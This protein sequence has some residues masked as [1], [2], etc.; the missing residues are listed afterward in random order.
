MTNARPPAVADMFYP[1][2][3]GI[4]A[5]TVDQLLADAPATPASRPKA[6]IVPHAGYIYSGPTA[7]RAYAQL[8]PWRA[9]VRRVILL[10]PT[11][12]VAVASADVFSGPSG[13]AVV[14]NLP[15]NALVRGAGRRDGI[16]RRHGR[17]PPPAGDKP[18][19]VRR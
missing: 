9:S 8:A 13:G 3:S 5:A 14:A 19:R 4:L 17:R 15:M 6:L 11:H 18:R 10:G 16:R 7:G 1:A 12:R 2:S